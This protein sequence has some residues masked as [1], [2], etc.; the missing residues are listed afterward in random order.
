MMK[1]GKIILTLV[2]LSYAPILFGQQKLPCE[3]A[4]RWW[5]GMLE[6]YSLPL[7]LSFEG[8]EETGM[9]DSCLQL[10]P[11][12][13]SPMQTKEPMVATK[14]SFAND[15]LRITHS[16]TG[17]KLTLRWNA[18]DSTFTGTF[19]Q[20]LSRMEVNMKPVG[21]M[22]SPNRPQTPQPPYPYNEEEVTVLRKKAGVTLTGTLTIPKGEGP[23]PAV[24]LVS[25]SGQQN[26]D[27]ELLGHKPF[28]VLADFLTRNGIAVLRYDDRGVGG[29]KGEVQNATTLDFADDAEAMFEW[30]RKHKCIDSRHVGILGH[31]EGGLIAP[32]VASRNK[33]VAFVVGYG[34]PGSTGAD[35]ILQQMEKIMLLNGTQK[36]LVE[37]KMEAVRLF[38]EMREKVVPEQ[39]Q[40][41]LIALFDRVSSGLSKEE[42]K[43][44]ELRKSDAM[45]FA[46]QIQIPWM[47][48]FLS[49]DNRDYLGKMHCRMLALNGEK[50]CQVL[51]VNIEFVAAAAKGYVD[52]CI[53]QDLNH[54]MQHCETGAP[55]EY[56]FI[57]E[58]LAPEVMECTVNWIKKVV[59][60]KKTM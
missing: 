59:R 22:F 4:Q 16:P 60:S 8:N 45:A 18:F 55:G 13:Y 29:S 52:V 56:M 54:L 15:T 39:Y 34:T 19:K 49:L 57:E 24:V 26:R 41:T 27:E 43:Q 9:P 47:K 5:L 30:L 2:F 50:D 44:A 37:K 48:T 17:V 40:D 6:E 46:Q 58:T 38:F 25:G 42:R 28:L 51:P 21:G 10:Y 35:I 7:N 23:F 1:S 36:K 33:K 31:S 11:V 53:M 3:F 32:I 14:W 12:L 20:G